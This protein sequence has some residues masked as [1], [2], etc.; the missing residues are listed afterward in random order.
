[1]SN[2]IGERFITNEGYEI[3]IIEYN[4]A[5][6]VTIQFQDE[7][8]TIIEHREYRDCRKGRIKN[9]YHPSICGVGYLGQGKYKPTISG[10][11]TDEYKEW[12]GM[13]RRA[14]DEKYKKKEPTYID[15]VVEEWLFNF[16]NYCEWREE[17]Y[18]EING[19]RMELDKDI[20]LKGNK[21]YSRDTIIFV[22]QRINSLFTKCDA[23]RGDCPIGVCYDKK[24]NKYVAYCNTLKGRKHLGSYNTSQ[25]AFKV[26]KAFKEAYIKEVANEYKNR[27]PKCLYD[28]MYNWEVDI[29][30]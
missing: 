21:I 26:Y 30:D 24:A 11:I 23:S 2:R 7:Y 28:A 10:K 6:D 3:V 8:K 12:H 13:L 9:P 27:I 14:Y 25:Q 20:L 18:Y 4:N 1:M 15:V 22:P 5:R 16:Q 29:N 17:N 19:E